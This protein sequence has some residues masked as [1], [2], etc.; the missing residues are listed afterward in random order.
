MTKVHC[1]SDDMMVN[2][3]LVW[4]QMVQNMAVLKKAKGTVLSGMTDS[5]WQILPNFRST[6][7]LRLDAQGMTAVM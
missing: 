1:E 5:C 2:Q 6:V 4:V 7:V 3:T